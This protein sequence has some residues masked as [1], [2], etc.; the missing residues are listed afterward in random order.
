MKNGPMVMCAGIEVSISAFAFKC[1]KISSL[2]SLAGWF[3]LEY[4]LKREL[5]LLKTPLI[6]EE[7]AFNEKDWCY[8]VPAVLVNH[9]RQTPAKR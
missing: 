2:T 7:N 5:W 1:V 3:S 9:R 6:N 8:A 4:L